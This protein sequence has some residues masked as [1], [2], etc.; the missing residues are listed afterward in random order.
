MSI[1]LGFQLGSKTMNFCIPVTDLNWVL[2]VLASRVSSHCTLKRVI[3][4]HICMVSFLIYFQFHNTTFKDVLPSLAFSY[5][6]SP[7]RQM[8]SHGRTNS[9][10][11]HS[12]L[13]QFFAWDFPSHSIRSSATQ[14]M[15]EGFLASSASSELCKI[16]SFCFLDLIIL[17]FPCS[18]S[19]HLFPGFTTLFIVVHSL[20]P[21][22]LE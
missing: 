1:S 19:A 4:G 18:S 6:F 8:S 13:A 22:T 10:S 3:Y 16:N 5:G 9:F 2:L 7:G 20:W 17:A 21:S 15:S 12:L 14:K 11:P